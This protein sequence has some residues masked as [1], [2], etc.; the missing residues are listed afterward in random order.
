MKGG[1]LA[2]AFL[3]LAAGP[4]AAVETGLSIYPKGMADFMSGVMPLQSGVYFSSIYYHF[5]GSADAAS[6]GANASS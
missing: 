2:F 3:V 6:T 1:P 5:N 4:A